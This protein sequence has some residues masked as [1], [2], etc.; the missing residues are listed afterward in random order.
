MAMA[1]IGRSASSLSPASTSA[2]RVRLRR[3][4]DGSKAGGAVIVDGSAIVTK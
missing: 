1:S 3:S 2:R 4:L